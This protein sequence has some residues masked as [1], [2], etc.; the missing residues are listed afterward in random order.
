[1]RRATYLSRVDSPPFAELAGGEVL[2]PLPG[3][4]R[5][6]RLLAVRA[7]SRPAPGACLAEAG[8]IVRLAHDFGRPGSLELHARMLPLVDFGLAA[9]ERCAA[10]A[11][12]DAL[13]RGA[14]SL[15]LLSRTAPPL[16][17][18]VRHEL[19]RQ[20]R[21][22]RGE[23]E[24]RVGEAP[25]H[26]IDARVATIRW[27]LTFDEEFEPVRPERYPA[28]LARLETWLQNAARRRHLRLP[29][30]APVIRRIA[31]DDIA[32]HA[33]LR[34]L[35][36]AMALLAARRRGRPLEAAPAAEP[37]LDDPYDGE[38]LRRDAKDGA[39]R[40]WSVG[41]DRADDGGEGD[42]ISM[43]FVVGEE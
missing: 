26:E 34:V 29:E 1:V 37:P 27:N 17:R 8:D 32:R 7:A 2:A 35:S 36:R 16:G 18:A 5:A 23:V 14:E 39:I 25:K 21:E 13:E 11:G 33:R 41:P 15:A 12:P 30:I 40:V 31:G 38:P 43:S 3:L 20:A 10:R 24:E 42:D 22:L 6:V 9:V 4:S 28:A 19:L